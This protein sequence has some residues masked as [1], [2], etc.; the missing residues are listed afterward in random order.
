MGFFNFLNFYYLEKDVSLKFWIF[1]IIIRYY[2]YIIVYSR[3]NTRLV[4]A[5]VQLDGVHGAVVA[6]QLRARDRRQ[7]PHPN[8]PIKCPRDGG[9]GRN[10]RGMK[11]HAVDEAGVL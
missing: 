7:I 10:A 3:D 8:D 9:D 1:I 6:L 5:A 2:C 4:P 11:A